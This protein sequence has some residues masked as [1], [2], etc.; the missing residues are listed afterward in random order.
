MERPL[1]RDEGFPAPAQGRPNEI[2]YSPTQIALCA[3]I[4]GP[5]GACWL[6]AENFG[7]LGLT[8]L[9]R[10]ARRWAMISTLLVTAASLFLWLELP[11]PWLAAAYTLLVAWSANHYQGEAFAEHQL[12]GGR[13]RHWLWLVPVSLASAV[14]TLAVLSLLFAV[15]PYQWWG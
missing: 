6:M 7:A 5:L 13:T 15:T 10:R 3:F 11:G 12:A 4:G 1:P 14:V 8:S 9:K 2:L